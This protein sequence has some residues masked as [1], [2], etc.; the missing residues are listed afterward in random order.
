MNTILHAGANHMIIDHINDTLP[1]SCCGFLFGKEENGQRQLL[2]AMR[3][4]GLLE[5]KHPGNCELSAEDY[6]AAEDYAQE[7]NL[8]LLGVY[9]SHP[10]QPA[11]PTER[12]LR[13]ALPYYSY[14]VI[15]IKK[16]RISQHTAWQLHKGR[17]EEVPVTVKTDE[18]NLE[19]LF[20]SN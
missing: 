16:N 4:E 5:N 20:S 14:L 2:Q 3:L 15:G 12:E 8:A 13:Q 7:N 18:F 11:V 17:F 10:D 19:R 6:M 9:I 1:G